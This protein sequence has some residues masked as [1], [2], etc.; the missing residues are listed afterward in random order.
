MK[1]F[2]IKSIIA[3]VLFFVNGVIVTMVMNAFRYQILMFLGKRA[4][5]RGEDSMLQI[6]WWNMHEGEYA[7]YI[8]IALTVVMFVVWN[9]GKN[10]KNKSVKSA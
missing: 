8:G 7:I 9:I 10:K 4:A 6:E 2:L 1:S 5:A 3:F